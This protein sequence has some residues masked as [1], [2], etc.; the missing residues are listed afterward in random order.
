M[1]KQGVAKL[2]P[3]NSPAI[4]AECGGG[5][6]APAGAHIVQVAP[7]CFRLGGADEGAEGGAKDASGCREI[8]FGKWADRH[9]CTPC[10]CRS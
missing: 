3:T 8:T 10:L 1:A 7:E 2:E 9:G 4:S 5:I 6:G